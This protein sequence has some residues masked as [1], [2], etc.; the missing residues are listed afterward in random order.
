MGAEAAPAPG[1]GPRPGAARTV[2]LYWR[3]LGRHVLARMS[4]ETDFLLSIGAS[5]LTQALGLIFLQVVFSRIPA[6]RGWTY[7]QTAVL[8]GL[9]LVVRGLAAAFGD[10]AWSL[11]GLIR[12]GGL[13]ALLLR[14]LPVWMQV[15]ASAFG[16]SAVAD[17]GLGAAV[18]AVAGPHAHVVWSARTVAALAVSLP[19]EPR[20]T[21]RRCSPPTPSASG[22]WGRGGRSPSSPTACRSWPSSPS[23]CTRGSWPPS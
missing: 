4:Y 20:C 7:W 14:P 22:P 17:V 2:W 12:D 6:V 19:S 9:L 8:Y 16:W 18:L 13:D 21:G 11:G 3:L 15:N 1:F 10:G 5:A 23:P